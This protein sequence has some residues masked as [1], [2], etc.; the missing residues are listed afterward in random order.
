MKSDLDF[1]EVIFDHFNPGLQPLEL[2]LSRRI[3]WALIVFTGVVG[4]IALSRLFFLNVARGGFYGE[5]AAVNINQEKIIPANRGLILDRFGEVLARNNPSFSVSLKLNELFRARQRFEETITRLPAILNL[6]KEELVKIIQEANLEKKISVVVGRHLTSDQV[7]NLKTLAL[8][9]VQVE[10]DYRR[11]Y[12]DGPV[13]AHILG[14]AGA[15][16]SREEWRGKTGLEAFYDDRLRGKDGRLVIFRDVLGKEIE[17]KTMNVAQ[18]GE[19]LTTAIDGQFQKYFHDRLKTGLASFGQRAGVGLALN[20]QNGEVLALISLPEFDNNQPAQYLTA[21]REPLFNRAISGVYNPGSTI[22]PLVAFAALKE[23]IISPDFE[24]YSPGYLELPN[25]FHPEEPSR[26]LDWRAHGM[27]NLYSALARSSN[28]YFYVLGG[29]YKNIRGLGIE[30]LNKYW[31]SFHLD[32]PT[33]IDLPAEATGFLPHSEE[34]EK[35]TGQIWRIGDTYNVSIGQGD[36]SLTPI[37]LLS[38]IASLGNGGKVYRPKIIKDN[39]PPELEMD[40]SGSQTEIETVRAGLR[41]AVRKS[42][43]TANLLAGLP[44]PVAGKTG[45]AQIAGNTKTNAFFVG[46]APADNPQIAILILVEEA[47]EGSLNALPIARDV[48]DWYFTHR[49]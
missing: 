8:P 33:G 37:R 35:R 2:P 21:A 43:G 18:P 46:Y 7:I 9:A 38:I 42:Y 5:R 16:D 13:F 24:F 4:F 19:E 32:Q 40:Y 39:L 12:P 26:F 47:R 14:Y 6:E 41:D 1:E 15:G 31:Q 48:L 49:P 45:S 27:V 29:G 3:F 20:P 22:K 10:D 23:K 11:E 25:P 28:V 30:R 44:R 36:L 17:Q 34:K